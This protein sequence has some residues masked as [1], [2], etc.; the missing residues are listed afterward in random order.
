MLTGFAQPKDY[1]GGG[2]SPRT[3]ESNLRWSFSKAN[4]L[5]TQ[6]NESD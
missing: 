2:I 5:T 3:V 4:P 6:L 1:E